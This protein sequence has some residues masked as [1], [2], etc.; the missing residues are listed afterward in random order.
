MQLDTGGAYEELPGAVA[1]F[2]RGTVL[3]RK[4]QG[5]ET[6]ELFS[7]LVRHPL[8]LEVCARASTA[9]TPRS[10]SSAPW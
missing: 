2:E 7:R 8:F 4:I 1:G 6:D 5:L 9:G 3:Y 10:R